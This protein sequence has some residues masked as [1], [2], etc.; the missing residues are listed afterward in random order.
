MQQAAASDRARVSRGPSRR[1]A[2]PATPTRDPPRRLPLRARRQGRRRQRWRYREAEPAAEQHARHWRY[3]RSN[4]RGQEQSGQEEGAE[5]PE[6]EAAP[7]TELEGGGRDERRGTPERVD[8]RVEPRSEPGHLAAS[9]RER[10]VD[11]IGGDR[12]GERVAPHGRKE[13]EDRHESAPGARDHVR[14]ASRVSARPSGVSR[15][16]TCHRSITIVA[17]HQPPKTTAGGG[18]QA[19]G[20]FDDALLAGTR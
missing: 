5:E 2:I 9:S 8:T 4:E 14:G 6:R 17:A 19:T 18:D 7:A 10:P 13:R 15:S 16:P 3:L 11:R 20:F 12:E 1:G